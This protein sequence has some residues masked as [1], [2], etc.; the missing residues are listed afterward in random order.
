MS[1][2]KRPLQSV[3]SSSRPHPKVLTCD[4]YV[5]QLPKLCVRS[6][7]VLC[8]VV[9]PLSFRWPGAGARVGGWIAVP[10]PGVQ[11]G[12]AAALM[13]QQE[14]GSREV[15]WAAWTWAAV[16]G[17]VARVVVRPLGSGSLASPGCSRAPS[18]A[19]CLVLPTPPSGHMGSSHPT[20]PWE[21]LWAG[22]GQVSLP[23][24]GVPFLALL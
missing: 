20:S 2:D 7:P 14:R 12:L 10:A 21:I 17:H 11:R 4:L 9:F 8:P 1:L 24:R 22:S 18:A 13:G 16:R 3:P 6:F 23:L 5:H 15:C 19:C